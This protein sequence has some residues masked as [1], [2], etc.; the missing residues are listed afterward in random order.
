MTSRIKSKFRSNK[1]RVVWTVPPA[2]RPVPGRGGFASANHAQAEAFGWLPGKL[3]E[4]NGERE[5]AR[6]RRQI[7]AGQLKP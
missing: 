7:A 6:R 3:Y 1:S 5:C 4:P 2:A